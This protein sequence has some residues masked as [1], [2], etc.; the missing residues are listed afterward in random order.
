MAVPSAPMG[1][2]LGTLLTFTTYGTW[3]RGDKRGWVDEGRIFP[4]DPVLEARDRARLKH[5]PYVFAPADLELAETAIGVA[6]TSRLK[7]PVLSLYLG[8][9]HCHAVVGATRHAVAEVAKC[10][11]DAA[12]YALQPDRPIWTEGY[13]KRWCFDVRSLTARIAYV[14]RHRRRDG[15]AAPLQSFIT[16]QAEYL[17]A[18][19]T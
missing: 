11:K 12:R 10:A 14:E 15:R 3:L 8:S 2:T 7:V 18:I 19:R 9:W 17:H 4:P 6:L 16:P 5:D 13:D 1:Y